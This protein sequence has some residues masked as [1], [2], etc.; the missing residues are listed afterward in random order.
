MIKIILLFLFPYYIY[1]GQ[2]SPY[3]SPGMQIGINSDKDL[4]VSI[5]T[6]IG[7]IDDDIIN[8]FYPPIGITFGKRFY[9]MKN[10]EWDSYNYID[11]QISTIWLGIGYG[12]IIDKNKQYNKFKIFG[13]AWGLLSYDYINWD[14]IKH[15]YGAFIVLPIRYEDGDF[16]ID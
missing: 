16:N 9:Y 14:K 5:Q 8:D 12:I 7:I 2:F 10:K 4:F 11:A 3:L 6:T 13:G 15:H 1:A